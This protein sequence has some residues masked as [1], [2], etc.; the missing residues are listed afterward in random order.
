[1]MKAPETR[2]VVYE[3][4]EVRGVW[5]ESEVKIG[6]MVNFRKEFSIKTEVDGVPAWIAASSM[7][8]PLTQQENRL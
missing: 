3:S 6:D 1:M 8:A 7:C 5:G 4:G 2:F